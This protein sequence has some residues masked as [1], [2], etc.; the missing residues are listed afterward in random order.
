MD[1]A[2][3]AFLQDLVDQ[4]IKDEHIDEARI[5]HLAIATMACHSSIRFHRNLTLAEMQQV[6]TDL[7]K[8][9]QPF[10]CPHGRPTFICITDEQLTKQ[11]L[12]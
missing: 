7:G 6:I 3:Q 10:H 4:W 1:A 8:C 12:R 2:E 11:F 9:E 5:R